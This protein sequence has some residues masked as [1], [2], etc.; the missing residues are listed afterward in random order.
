MCKSGVSPHPKVWDAVNSL[1]ERG[2]S[3]PSRAIRCQWNLRAEPGVVILVRHHTKCL[4]IMRIDKASGYC[5]FDCRLP[6]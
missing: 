4:D 6:V 3:F 2:Y 5:T 1:Q